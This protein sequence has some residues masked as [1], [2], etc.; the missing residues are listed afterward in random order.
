MFMLYM[1]NILIS[2]IATCWNVISFPEPK[3]IFFNKHEKNFFES[4]DEII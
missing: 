4:W 2:K 3:T 1:E